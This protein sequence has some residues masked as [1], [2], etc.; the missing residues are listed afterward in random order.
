MQGPLV[1]LEMCQQLPLARA[2]SLLCQQYGGADLKTAHQ[3]YVCHQVNPLS[4]SEIEDF[5]DKLGLANA[6]IL[7]GDEK[8]IGE[9]SG[10]L[11]E[12]EVAFVD[13]VC[14]RNTL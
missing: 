5:V 1:G 4:D 7:A 3:L 14:K 8:F 2:S 9:V 11:S 12:A 10:L 13:Q 6:A